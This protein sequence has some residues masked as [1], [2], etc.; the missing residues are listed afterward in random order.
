MPNAE[1]QVNGQR[2]AIETSGDPSNP[3]IL[4]LHYIMGTRQSWNR[5]VKKFVDRYQCITVDF[6]GHGD[7]SRPAH[8]YNWEQ[9][10]AR[11]IAALIAQLPST[12]LFLV[13]HS[14]GAMVSLVV[15]S[16]AQPPL[17]GIFLEEPPLFE[18]AKH[19][20]FFRDKLRIRMLPFAERVALFRGEGQNDVDAEKSARWFDNFRPAVLE[21]LISGNA[22]FDAGLYLP[23]VGCPMQIALGSV[24]KG[25]VITA[26]HRERLR[27]LQVQMLSFDHCGHGI[28][29]YDLNGF[30][31][32]LQEF[33]T[34][35]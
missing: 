29:Q 6:R 4:F 1:I 35:R 26:E 19:W 10:F 24:E 30:C 23:R 14:L 11:D 5:V 32:K 20:D 21:E 33:L 17:A 15:A 31:A 16:Q 28:H 34:E 8:G 18:Q 27:K 3:T 9:D 25:G 22:T 12:K 13:G 7:S 2:L